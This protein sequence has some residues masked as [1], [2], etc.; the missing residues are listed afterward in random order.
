MKV[1]VH[2][3]CILIV[4]EAAD[5]FVNATSCTSSE[6]Y[7]TPKFQSCADIKNHYPASPSGYYELITYCD[8]EEDDESDEGIE[9]WTRVAYLNMSDTNQSCPSGFRL[10]QSGGVR[11]CGRQASSGASCQSIKFQAGISYS[12]VRGKVVGYQYRSPDAVQ[13]YNWPSVGKDPNH[14]DINSHYVDGVSITHGSP[15]QHIWTMMGGL[16]DVRIHKEHNCPCTNGSDQSSTVP[17]FIG[18]DYFC[19]SGNPSPSFNW[20]STL[21]TADPLWDGEGCGPIEQACCSSRPSLP[22]F[23]KTLNSTTTDYIELRVCADQ[24]TNDEDVP[25]SFYEI[26]IK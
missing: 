2:F 26:Y 18:N 24:G 11:A 10:Y 7:L 6:S 9:G 13:N 15:R 1:F 21:H 5:E 25:V 12:Q 17:S 14:N 8:M 20:K 22:W 16:F 3:I 19:E 23:N 4:F